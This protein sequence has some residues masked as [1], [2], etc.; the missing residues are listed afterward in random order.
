MPTSAVTG[1][2]AKVDGLRNLLAEF[3]QV[4]VCFSGGVD[5][6]YLLAEAVKVL[7][8][9]VTVAVSPYDLQKGRITFR[10]K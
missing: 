4:V 9:R 5:S 1:I 7:G 10:H 2:D 8:D 6:G 3:D